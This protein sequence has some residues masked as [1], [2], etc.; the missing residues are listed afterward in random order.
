MQGSSRWVAG[1]SQ[2]AGLAEDA[3]C[4]AAAQRSRGLGRVAGL[5]RSGWVP[6]VI[7]YSNF[8]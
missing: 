4:F 6:D 2:V 8:R 1:L 3:I 5:N 7:A